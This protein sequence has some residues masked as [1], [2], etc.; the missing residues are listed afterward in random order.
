V[1]G[2]CVWC[3]CSRLTPLL[4]MIWNWTHTKNKKFTRWPRLRKLQES[5]IADS[6]LL[7]ML[8][9]TSYFCCKRPTTNWPGLF[10]FVDGYSTRKTSCETVPK[11]IQSHSLGCHFKKRQ[12]TLTASVKINQ[13]YYIE[14]VLENH[15][16]KHAKNL[17]SEDYFCWQQKLL[18]DNLPDY[19]PIG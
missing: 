9:M 18:E 19:Q 6:T 13:D 3:W 16:F 2:W 1:I 17:H 10:C 15:L 14:H 11:C 8:L 5:K 4:K 12:F 7:G